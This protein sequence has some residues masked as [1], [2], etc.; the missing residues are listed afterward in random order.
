MASYQTNQTQPVPPLLPTRLTT[1]LQG[2]QLLWEIL[3]TRSSPASG[4]ASVQ[5]CIMKC[6]FL[7][8]G[9]CQSPTED[10]AHAGSAHDRRYRRPCTDSGNAGVAEMRRDE[11]RRRGR[12]RMGYE[13]EGKGEAERPSVS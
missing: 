7:R 12:G 5:W 8:G 4:A 9:N 2:C 6:L 11:G 3:Q 10:T 1:T 13:K